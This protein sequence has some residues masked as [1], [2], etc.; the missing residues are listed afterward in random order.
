MLTNVSV[1]NCTALAV[2]F[3]AV[4]AALM[5]G[6]SPAEATQ[7]QPWEMG[8]QPPATPIKDY[9]SWFHDILLVIITIITVFVLALLLYTIVRFRAAANPTPSRTTHNT[10]LEIVWTAVP[11]LTLVLIAIPSIHLIRISDKAPEPDFT[12]KVTGH[13][14]YW[15]YK[16]P[17]HGDFEYDSYMVQEADLKPGQTRL[18]DVDNRVV[19]PVGATVRVEIAGVDVIHSWFIPSMGVQKYAMPGRLNETWFQIEKPGVYYGQ[20]NQICGVNHGFMP[21]AVEAVDKPT[22]DKW[23]A[24]AKKRFADGGQAPLSVA[25]IQALD[26]PRVAQNVSK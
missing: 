4:L 2:T 16:Y 20:C 9:I 21:I 15:S 26:A 3:I 11:V 5:L 24:E 23:A 12:L 8:F 6:A 10:L 13:Q 22:F 14:W 19:V 7:P 18:L 25:E 17:D 1:R